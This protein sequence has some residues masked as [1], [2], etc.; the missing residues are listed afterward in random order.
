MTGERPCNICRDSR[1]AEVAGL[2]SDLDGEYY[3]VMKCER[4]GLLYV[5][6]LPD[7]S[8]ENLRKIYGDTY[9]EKVYPLSEDRLLEDALGR[10]MAIVEQYGT[11][12][13]VLNVGAMSGECRILTDRGWRLHIV[14]ASAHAAERARERWGVEITVSKIEDYSV[15]PGSYDFIKLGHVIEHLGDPSTTVAHLHGM[16]RAGGLILIDTDNAEGLET[17]VEA[18]LMGLMRRDRVR[19]IAEKLAGKK[20]NLRSGRL[21]PPVHLY[22]FTMKSLV[23]L[24]RQC[25]FEVVATFNASWGDPTWFPLSKRSVI[26]TLFLGIDH[27]GAMLG[28]GNVIAVLARKA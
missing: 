19:R 13:D 24:V 3:R 20:Y 22:T 4:C 6:P 11:I 26:E 2:R 5:D 14:E 9:V 1:C 21:T 8:P 28:R 23:S 17:R 25:G 27:I 12:G 15:P 16:L 18:S 7:L 10:Q